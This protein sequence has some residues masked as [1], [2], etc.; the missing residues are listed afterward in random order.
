MSTSLLVTKLFI[1]PPRPNAV[2]RTR[3]LARLNDDVQRKLTLISAPAGFGK[4]SLLSAW[5]IGGER[6]TAWLTLDERDNEPV[7]FLSHVIA[8]LQSVAPGIGAEVESALQGPQP[9]STEVM[10]TALLNEISSIQGRI[11]LVL[12]D[13]HMADSEP[14]DR[15]VD[16]LLDHL[17]SQLHLVIATRQDPAISLSRLRTRGQMT[18]LRASDLRF[19]TAEA[20]DF[21]NQSMGLSLSEADVSALEERT[22]GWV[23]GL[24]LAALSL[25]GHQDVSGFIRAFA[26]DHRYIVDY[27]VDEVLRAQPEP[28][29][30]FLLQTSILERLSGRLCDAVTGHTDGAARL[31][32]LERGNFF[33][34]PLDD[35]RRW[36]RYHRLFADVLFA[37]LLAEQS[38]QVAM[39]RTRASVWYE[40]Q[41][42]F[43][44]AIRHSLAAGDFPRVAGLVELAWPSIRQSRQESALQDWLTRLPD[45]L[46]RARPVLGA[47]YVWARLMRG[48][49]EGVEVRLRDVERWLDSTNVGE[50]S[51]TSHPEMVIV[52]EAEFRHLPGLIALMRAA[53]A[54]MLGNVDDTM[55]HAG[56]VLDLTSEDDYLLRGSAAGLLGLAYWTLG[57]LAAAHRAYVDCMNAVLK[58]GHLSD[59]IGCAV[60]VSDLQMAQ[61]RLRDALRTCEDGLQLVTE[62]GAPVLR[63]AADMHVGLG[64]L[65]RERN[66][67][68]AAT[69]HLQKCRDLGEHMGL[70]QTPYRWCAAMARIKEAQGDLNGALDL[71]DEAQ[72]RYDG[73][74]FPN[75]RPIAAQKARLWVLQGRVNEALE[76]ARD[77]GLSAQ[78]ELSYLR[79]FEH[80]MLARA[81]LA[82][83]SAGSLQDAMWL[84]DRLLQAAEAGKRIRSVIEILVLQSLAHFTQG[85]NSAAHVTLA[86][87]LTL[88]EPE[89]YVR[90]FVDE[91][92]AMEK[93]LEQA[94]KQGIAPDYVGL[95]RGAFGITKAPTP[96]QQNLIEPL[97]ERELDV[98][99]LLGTELGGPEIA[100]ELMVSLNTM[101]SHTKNIYTKLGVNNRRAAVRRADEL[102]LFSRAPK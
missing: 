90:I 66:E 65:L 25:Q 37:R 88:G 16:F 27:L 24:Q 2:T 96:R 6:A 28:F 36:Y 69:L 31:E 11:M 42:L 64:T 61:G 14:V 87:A 101:R 79:E 5:T 38:E 102:A 19:S 43:A 48:D 41:G 3:L 97:S 51:E 75:I 20:A 77:Q 78:D 67:L 35:Q 1:P 46:I 83:T 73:D 23:A 30:M 91:G 40:E 18:E 32:M 72:R 12:D 100:N 4:T 82:D 8:A 39:L 33:V 86:R 58:A 84:L 85:D 74:F 56:R 63:G 7:R 54:R 50:R 81:L 71:L 29:R 49:L 80:V 21:L 99:R 26:G 59:A 70:P 98:L 89:G 55:K 60:A 76:W 17:P 53:Q 95:L 94:A 22:E 62:P 68:D 10:L 47:S 44:D 34:V 15:A 9:P 13:Y 92:P 57:D 45:E 52:N 93:L